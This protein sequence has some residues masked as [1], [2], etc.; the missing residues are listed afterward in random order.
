M[1][2]SAVSSRM[3]MIMMMMIMMMMMRMM[4]T[5]EGP[6]DVDIDG[7]DGCWIMMMLIDVDD[8]VDNDGW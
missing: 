5:S 1:P 4:M 2:S 7:D 6:D 3:M 8:A